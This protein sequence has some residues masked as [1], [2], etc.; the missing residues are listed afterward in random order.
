MDPRVAE[1]MPIIEAFGLHTSD[2]AS[3]RASFHEVCATFP[4]P[5]GV[6]VE[7]VELGGRP[8]LRFRPDGGSDGRRILHLHGGAF[9]IGD[10]GVQ[11][12]MPASLSRATGAE[13]VSLDY[14]VA[15]EHPCPAA[16]EDAVAAYLELRR[17]GPVAAIAGESAGGALVVLAAVALRDLGAPPPTAL[18]AVS[19]WVD[20][21][22][23][24]ERFAD[25]SF[26][27]PV[28]SRAFL[29]AAAAAWQGGLDA[30]DERLSPL[31]ADLSGLAPTLVHVGG[32]ELLVEDS[33]RL[34]QRLALAGGHVELRVVADMPHVFAA[35]PTLAPECDQSLSRI[36]GFLTDA[37]ALPTVSASSPSGT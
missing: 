25:P 29:S 22:A 34:A 14:R 33:T 11:L 18:V 37:S 8:G 13:V 7:S 17:D 12:A 1:L 24:S 28:L 32:D 15:P 6:T 31:Q 26:R 27:D 23:T 9:V 30:A 4:P 10:L 2:I 19:P 5:E 20:L 16:I 35:Y 3:A 21:W 36:A